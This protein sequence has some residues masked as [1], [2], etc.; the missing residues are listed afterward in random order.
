[1]QRVSMQFRYYEQRSMLIQWSTP[2]DIDEYVSL[3]DPHMD[4]KIQPANETDSEKPGA[5]A[6][7]WLDL[8]GGEEDSF[9]FV[10]EGA[11]KGEISAFELI[12]Y[13]CMW[14]REHNADAKDV[15]D[16]E[17]LTYR[18]VSTGLIFLNTSSL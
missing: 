17:L 4:F 1:M 7:T 2:S 14:E 16:A 15:K 5:M 10:V 9:L 13:R 6:L 11:A 8:A 3:I 18:Y 12:M